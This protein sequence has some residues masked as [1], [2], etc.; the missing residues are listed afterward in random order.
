MRK[1]NRLEEINEIFTI[2]I[3]YHIFCFTDWVPDASVQ[4]NLG[5]SCL[6]FNFLHLGFNLIQ[7]ISATYSEMFKR[8]RLLKFKRKMKKKMKQNNRR[9]SGLEY[10]KRR[11]A[12]KMKYE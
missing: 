9:F 12:H 5:Y 10:A 6:F 1:L 2:F 11:W 8:L 4:Y 3:M 7:I